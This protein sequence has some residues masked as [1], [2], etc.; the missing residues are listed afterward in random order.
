MRVHTETARFLQ[1]VG[2]WPI[3]SSTLSGSAMQGEVEQFVGL[4]GLGSPSSGNPGIRSAAA[5]SQLFNETRLG[6]ST[7]DPRTAHGWPFQHKPPIA[8]LDALAAFLVATGGAPC[9]YFQYS[10]GWFDADWSW[11]PLFDQ[12]YGTATSP[13]VI[14]QYGDAGDLGEVWERMFKWRG[15]DC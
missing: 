11:D 4:Q 5:L 2:K 13:P 10:K 14:T 9:T 12:E 15:G 6:L 7:V 8:L 1:T 3:F